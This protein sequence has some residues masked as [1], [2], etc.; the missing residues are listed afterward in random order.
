MKRSKSQ[1][2]LWLL[3]SFFLLILVG[4]IPF[5]ILLY[6]SFS[7]Y[8]LLY[9]DIPRVFVGFKNFKNLVFD[10]WTYNALQTT[11][12]FVGIALPLEMLIGLGLAL[13][14]S[15][16]FK[17]ITLLRTI[18]LVPLVIAPLVTGLIWNQ[19]FNPDFGIITYFLH[20]LGLFLNS[21]P[22]IDPST[23]L[24]SIVVVDIW[25]WTPFVMLI[26]L[27]GILA[28]PK[29]PF[30][31]AKID[32]ASKWQIFKNITLPLIRYPL[33]VAFL[34]RFMEAFKIFDEI[35]IIT[36]GGPGDATRVVSIH[37]YKI[38]FYRWD[39]GYGAAIALFLE[40]IT[41]I[42]CASFYKVLQ[43]SD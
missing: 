26:I 6:L 22:T 12:T 14:F 17:G 38:A 31:A 37:N 16:P 40:Y 27:S 29:E 36:G 39:L 5:F 13:L 2:W 11:F 42:L 1:P 9:P 21:G 30:E 35:W 33:T 15:R 34:L 32:G 41:I 8:F 7:D 10:P 24:F 18:M 4:I 43:K 23:A 3:P 20:S 28:L 25:H 19:M